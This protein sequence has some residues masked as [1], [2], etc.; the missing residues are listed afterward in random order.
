M[1]YSLYL[2]YNSKDHNHEITNKFSEPIS[3]VVLY[4]EILYCRYLHNTKCQQWNLNYKKLT[5]IKKSKHSLLLMNSPADDS[6]KT[7]NFINA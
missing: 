3:M 4:T 2:Q 7:V 5:T 6:N 1:R